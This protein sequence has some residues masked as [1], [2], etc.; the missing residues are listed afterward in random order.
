[1]PDCLGLKKLIIISTHPIQYNAPLFQLLTSRGNIDV[2]VLYTWGQADKKVFDPGFGKERQWDVPLLEGY[3][4]KFLENISATP[5]SH[6]FKGIDNPAILSEVNAYAPDAILVYGWSFKSHLKIMRHFKGKV[7]ILFRGD[8]T[9]LDEPAG[10]SIRKLM[11]CLWLKWI[12]S[13]VDSALYVG[14]A[15]KVY[16]LKHG[17]QNKQLTFAPHAIDNNR[18]L[19]TSKEDLRGA[20][21]IPSDDIIFLFAGKFEQKKD[22]LLFLNAFIELNHESAWLLM[23]GSG[24]LEPDLKKLAKAQK[25]KL[26]DRIHFLPFQNQSRMPDIYKTCDIFV[27]PSQGPGETWGLAVNEAMAC[28]KAV[29]VS[30]RC[31]ASIDLVEHGDNGFVFRHKDFED[32]LEKMRVLVN[33]KRDLL[34]MGERSLVIIKDWIYEKDAITIEAATML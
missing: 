33:S 21:G 20:L 13:H 4:Y 6:H 9:L 12:Y 28:A 22:P 14:T 5:G 17:L 1:M 16:Y 3:S 29:L 24:E 34:K 10:F 31:G 18:F 19:T 11:R 15:N 30:D 26:T 2:K 23:V 7:K 8:S 32:L 27:L 25:K